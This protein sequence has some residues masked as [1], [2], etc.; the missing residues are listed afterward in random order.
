MDNSYVRNISVKKMPKTKLP[1]LKNQNICT[2]FDMPTTPVCMFI[3]TD[4]HKFKV[5][6]D[7]SSEI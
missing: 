3:H 6:I 5:I 2:Y 7:G 1:Q 4:W